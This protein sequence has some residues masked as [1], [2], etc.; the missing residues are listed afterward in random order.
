MAAIR[1]AII[2]AGPGGLATLKTLLEASS[3]ERPIECCLFEAENDIGGTFQFRSYENAELVSSKQLT[4]FS[5]HRFPLK[6]PDHISLPQYVDYLKAYVNRF[7]LA[8][9]IKLGCRVA[10]VE[11]LSKS[12]NEQWKHRVKYIDSHQGD[13]EQ[14][15]DCSHIA[16]CTGL[17]VQPNVPTI[18]GIENVQGE[19]FHSSEYKLRS[20]LSGRN[21]L[22][23]GCGETA[24]DIAYEAIK[25]D[26]TAVTMCFR[27]G[28]L[29]FPKAL[30]RFQVFGKVFKGGLPI[31]GLIT[32]LF[33][34][35]YVHRAVAKSRLR[36]FV[37]DFV[38][39]R[40]L[41]FLTGTQAG[42]NQHVGALPDDR[43]GRAY[44]FLN[45]STKAMPYLNRPYQE[46][47]PLG[48]LGNGYVD[49]P[50][51]AASKRWVD[52]CS[53]P[54]RI[55]ESGKVIF[56]TRPDRKDWRRLKDAEVRPNCI[57]Y[58]TGYKQ[59][60]SW[61][62]ASYPTSSDAIV[63]NIINPSHPDIAFIGF[64][65]PGVGAIPPI[66]EQQAMWWT[67]LLLGQMKMPTDAPHYH[68]LARKEA[69]IQYG[70][71]HSAYMSTLAKDFGGAPGLLQLYQRHG[72][73]ILLTYCFGASFVTFYRLM[74]PFESPEAPRIAST[75]L[76]ESM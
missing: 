22:I 3:P 51:D 50:E 4:A 49:P 73:R 58:C 75:E 66:A 39:K 7:N 11:P 52:T 13:Q 38:I 12:T 28:F 36:W 76:A 70:V 1:V 23:L 25:A 54:E 65:R 26:A 9:F 10:H 44:V 29:S 8:P 21:V 30:S 2:G 68:L 6:T 20:Q 56:E 35:A 42:M 55:D 41:W 34:T 57:V 61:L 59:V 19:V 15:Y 74:G 5:D 53:F 43:L 67:A 32:N 71:D 48:F 64:V 14:V 18:P 24:M 60:F 45:K 33:E 17:H 63:R 69:R 47:H 37:S 31:D 16:I 72:L 40:V 27:T 46:K 62:D